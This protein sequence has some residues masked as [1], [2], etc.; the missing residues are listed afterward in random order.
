M[1][2]LGARNGVLT[3]VVPD[4]AVRVLLM[5][6]DSL[7]H[8]AADAI[9]LLRFRLKKMLPFDV[10][11][12]AVSYQALPSKAGARAIVAVLPNAVLR[13]YETIIREAGFEPGVVLPSTLACLG[14]LTGD[15]TALLVHSSTQCVTTAIS[16]GHE[17]LLHRTQELPWGPQQ[18]AETM[19][20]TE[21]AS[22]GFQAAYQ[23]ERPASLV[24]DETVSNS[25]LSAEVDALLY[26]SI[27]TGDFLAADEVR[28]APEIVWDTLAAEREEPQIADSEIGVEPEVAKSLLE[29]L[30][31]EL[32]MSAPEPAG[33]VQH[34]PDVIQ[35]ELQHALAVAAAYFEDSTGRP[36]APILVAGAM[37][38]RT[39]HSMLG[40]DSLTLRDL[41]TSED[42]GTA[43]DSGL[44]RAQ[45]GAVC[46]ALR[47]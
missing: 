18:L 21:A 5:D 1:E 42:L 45:L 23:E 4:Q 13:E 39:W 44:S 31:S 3:L 27:V 17:L 28:S 11:D 8:K 6:F 2:S 40:D 30:P 16:T 34:E 33:E 26:P 19:N 25:H 36:P 15:E 29:E 14:M 37:D 24:D 9:P 35:S 7:P 38:A 32:E 41:V 12:A 10:D 20:P 43:F 46:G 47:G 22:E